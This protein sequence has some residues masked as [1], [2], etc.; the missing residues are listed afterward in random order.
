MQKTTQTQA[1]QTDKDPR[2]DLPAGRVVGLDVHPDTFTAALI[3]GATPAQAVVEKICNRVPIGQL[4]KWALKNTTA[5]DQLVM[6]A[7]GNSFHV[8][9]T[10]RAIPRQA[11]VLESVQMGKLKEAHANNDRISAVRIGKAYLA[12]TAKEVW[13]PDA[14]TQE[15]RDWMHAHRKV[16]KRCTQVQNRVQSYLSDQGVRLERSVEPTDGPMLRQARSW[17]P[18]QW[19]LLEGMLLELDHA[20]QQRVHWVSLIAQ[21]V[22]N[23]P[24]LLSLT[25]LCG[26]R[27][28]IAFT[29]GAVIGD[30]HRFAEPKKLVKYFGLNPAFDDSGENDW[31]GG[32]AGHGRKDVRATLIEAAQ[33]I[34]RTNHP[35]AKWGKRLLARKGEHNLVVAAVARKLTVAI[36]YLLMGRETPVQDIDPRTAQKVSKMITHIGPKA[37]QEMGQ[38][39][40]QLREKVYES[41]KNGRTYVLDPRKKMQAKDPALAPGQPPAPTT[42]RPDASPC[43]STEPTGFASKVATGGA[44]T[45]DLPSPRGPRHATVAS[46]RSQPPRRA[47]SRCSASLSAAID[48]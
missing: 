13:M 42:P 3:S 31:S 15:R 10:L 4:K 32:I 40:R 11:K 43:T 5:A 28:I 24:V 17:T 25:R 22:L 46:S 12:G 41:L 35:L 36:W 38:T 14:L 44:T 19:Q 29:L 18:R 23:D 26:I 20:E 8:A 45:E 1:E 48:P 34:L 39:R 30:I 9:R 21:E 37:I 16:V 47:A 7:S 2:S 33:A 6:E 27:D